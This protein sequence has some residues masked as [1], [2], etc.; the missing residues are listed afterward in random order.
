ML[1]RLP[2]DLSSFRTL[3]EKGYLYVDKTKYAY[4]LINQGRRYFLSR[5]RR[6]GKSLFVSTLKEILYG[7]KA[8]FEGLWIE[9]SNYSWNQYG[10]ITLDLSAFGINSEKTFIKGVCYALR[11]IADKYEL[12]I[13]V[14]PENVA[15]A[16]NSVVKALYKKFG[17]VAIF[18]DEYDYPI[19]QALRDV[20]RAKEIRDASRHLFAAIKALD[21]EVD[22]VFITGVSSFA[23]A[24]LFS[25]MNNLRIVTLDERYAS[26]CGYDENEID[27][28]LNPHI[29]AWADA[30]KASYDELRKSIREWYNGY[31]FGANV[32]SVYNPFSL[33]NA[34]D[35][36]AFKNFWFQ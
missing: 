17:H 22:F 28:Y 3:R 8:L 2:L 33:M 36:K 5:P 11:D 15:L 18:I 10:V 32:S 35:A 6:F 34:I 13:T 20:E 1:S 19:L 31:R 16:L 23:K 25:G 7:N 4:D 12:T 9:N 26:V 14:N 30:E 29:K 24:G 21:E 27:Q